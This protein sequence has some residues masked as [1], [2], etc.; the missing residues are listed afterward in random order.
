MTR[1]RIIEEPGKAFEDEATCH[2]PF[3]RLK[4]TPDKAMVVDDE[5]NTT[6]TPTEETIALKRQPTHHCRFKSLP[7]RDGAIDRS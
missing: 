3:K 4:R 2:R 1:T 7:V 6:R 5:N